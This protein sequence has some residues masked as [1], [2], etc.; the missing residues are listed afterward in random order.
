MILHFGGINIYI[1]KNTMNTQLQS[2]SDQLFDIKEKCSDMEYKTIMDT[3]NNLYSS[4]NQQRPP[5]QQLDPYYELDGYSVEEEQEF[6]REVEERLNRPLRGTIEWHT[7]SIA[8]QAKYC[9]KT[10][11]QYMKDEYKKP[12]WMDVEFY[13]AN[14]EKVPTHMKNH[15]LLT[16]NICEMCIIC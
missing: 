3:M 9:G 4:M 12:H 15:P 13:K 8:E 16:K 6:L 5:L 7:L 11:D 10:V 2:L 14:P 1:Y